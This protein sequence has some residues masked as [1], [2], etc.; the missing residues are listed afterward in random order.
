MNVPSVVK[1]HFKEAA[2]WTGGA[3]AAIATPFL[4]E[5]AYRTH[6][7]QYSS[8]VDAFTAQA[9]ATGVAMAAVGAITAGIGATMLNTYYKTLKQEEGRIR[10]NPAPKR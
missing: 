10:R 8:L 6:Q 3:L 5:I 1:K 4:A 7:E 2:T 9:T